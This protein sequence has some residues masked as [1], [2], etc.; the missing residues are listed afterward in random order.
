MG[1]TALILAPLIVGG[2]LLAVSFWLG[3]LFERVRRD[4]AASHISPQLHGELVDLAR[5]L[6]DPGM[7]LAQAPYLP[8]ALKER[9]QQLFARARAN[10]QAIARAERRRAGY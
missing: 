4:V 2:A 6:L 8:P 1:K 9:V 7:D 10:Q 3:R 5:D